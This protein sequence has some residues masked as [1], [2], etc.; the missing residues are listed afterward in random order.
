[1]LRT[2]YE[3]DGW[4][5]AYNVGDET[6]DAQHKAIMELFHETLNALGDGGQI[7]AARQLY[8]KL[9]DHIRIHFATEE[10]IMCEVGYPDF[11]RH[12]QEHNVLM[13]EAELVS[14]RLENDVNL[15]A[16]RAAALFMWNLVVGHL[17]LSDIKL[18][19][20]LPH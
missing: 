8:G 9:M 12:Q 18:R 7:K 19:D 6:M 16:A 5:D 14:R 10:N 20:H 13:I 11:Q 3:F 2:N 15:V 17:T 1:M 4:N